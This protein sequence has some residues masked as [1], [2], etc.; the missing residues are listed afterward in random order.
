MIGLLE[1]ITKESL[2]QIVDDIEHFLG[3]EEGLEKSKEEKPEEEKEIKIK[4]DSYK[5]SVI[6][7]L[8]EQIAASSCFKIYNTY[9]KAHGMASFAEPEWE[10]EKWREK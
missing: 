3:K 4:K 2:V 9:K 8:S 10:V 7:T 1:G 5:E 6:R